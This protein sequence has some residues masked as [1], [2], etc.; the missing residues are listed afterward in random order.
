MK[1]IVDRILN[2]EA[3]DIAG[4]DANYYLSVAKH[5]D[6]YKVGFVNPYY[7]IDHYQHLDTKELKEAGNLLLELADELES[8]KRFKDG[9][10]LFFV[11]PK[12]IVIYLSFNGESATH[13]GLVMSGNAF[14]TKTEAEENRGEIMKKYQ[15]LRD[16]GL[17]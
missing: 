11:N 5:N 16:R 4:D 14:K 13:L 9:D 12:G 7:V 6:K 1:E 8:R 15:E 3:V 2:G 17:V 10:D